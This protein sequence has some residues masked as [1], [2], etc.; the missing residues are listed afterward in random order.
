MIYIYNRPLL[1]GLL[2]SLKSYTYTYDVL[3]RITG[4]TH[5]DPNYHLSLVAYDKMGNIT[6]L[7][8]NG[9]RD[10]SAS[11][12]GLMD[13]LTYSYQGNQ[14]QAVDDAIA[15]SAVTGFKDGAE[16][17][18][19]YFYD[20]NGNMTRDDNKGI[21]NISY[22]HLN[23]PVQISFASG[24]IQ[25]IYDVSGAKLKK[26]VT[27]GSSVTVTDYANGFV[28][29]NNTLQFFNT[30]E[31]YVYKDGGGQFR[32]VYQYRDHLN[33][34]RVSYTDGNGD[35][36]ITQDELIEENTYYPFGLLV[37]GINDGIG[38]LGN[39]VAQRWK[40]GG[41]E[42][43]DELNLQ[44]Y[45][46]TAR[47]YDPALGRWMNI[48]P[49]A[50][51]MR[52]HSPY[53]YAFDNPIYFIDPDGRAPSGLGNP[54]KKLVNKAAKKLGRQGKQKRLK[55]IVND[56]KA[57]KA[58]KGWVKSE[59]NQIEKGKRKSIRNPP[60]KDLAHE[61]GREAA[62]GYGYEHSN[63]Q[64]RA[65]HRRQHKYDDYGRKNKERPIKEA[66]VAA[67]TM[68]IEEVNASKSGSYLATAE[69]QQMV[70]NLGSDAAALGADLT[71]AVE[72]PGTFIFGADSEFGKFLDEINPMNLGFSDLFNFMDETLNGSNSSNNSKTGTS[73][74]SE[75][76]IPL[77]EQY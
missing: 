16:A 8:R 6:R 31:G 58:D 22:N 66:V 62:K 50:E 71:N 32:Y 60:G 64:N 26:T 28:Y 73:K 39:S 10:V 13:D 11:S 3:N 54:I 27:E 25:Y 1:R 18:T 48:D 45:D 38:A 59:M 2:C 68:A 75:K 20:G 67:G 72:K 21:T 5:S 43:Q 74:Y 35:G 77:I 56:P 15:A 19:E 24:N 41:K 34:I 7:T 47:N 37:R 23:L 70:E 36:T 29:E 51:Q 12:F 42:L 69:N 30:A 40:F 52:R 65:D 14:L 61:R 4:A 53:N 9:H 33:N 63:L 57:S 17:A 44:W 76:P 55:Q 46:I 49:L